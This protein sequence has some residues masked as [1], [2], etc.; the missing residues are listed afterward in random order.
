[1]HA[2]RRYA[3]ETFGESALFGDDALRVRAVAVKAGKY[4]AT[5]VK[6]SV[7]AIETLI[8]FELHANSERL[9]NR[10]MLESLKVCVAG[11]AQPS[12]SQFAATEHTK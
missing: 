6:W 12:S 11:P 9:Y 8:G 7:M 3:P 2:N 5:I 1:M 10:K 4:G